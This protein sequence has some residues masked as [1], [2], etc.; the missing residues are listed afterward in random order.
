[1]VTCK[2]WNGERL[3]VLQPDSSASWAINKRVLYGMTIFSLAI[4]GAF[5]AV[6]AWVV[7]PFAGLE[8]LALGSALYWVSWKQQYRHVLHFRDGRLLIEKGVYYPKRQWHWHCSASRIL[9]G[10]AAHFL[11]PL[12][13]SLCCGGETVPIGDFLGR[14]D[15]HALLRFLKE[16]GLR[17]GQ[18]GPA[19]ALQA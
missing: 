9:V 1:M 19:S 18:Y 13:I 16:Q 2:T 14:E 4:A 6:G 17:V 12:R 8:M 15:S 3:I 7:L 11:D 10:E 5:A